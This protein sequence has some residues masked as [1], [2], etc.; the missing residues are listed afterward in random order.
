MSLDLPRLLEAEQLE[1]LLGDPRLLLVDCSQPQTYAQLHVPGAVHVPPAELVCGQPPAPGMLPSLERLEALFS[2]I[3]YRPEQHIVAYD[4]EGGGW[5]GR[6]LWTLEVIGHQAW[7]Y[8]NGGL[9]AWFKEGH[10][11]ENTPVQREPA[12]VSLSLRPGVIAELED[13]RASLERADVKIWD[14]RSAEE[15]AGLKQTARRNG[16]IPGAVNL[17]W[18]DT[19]DRERNLR[20]L[21]LDSLRDKLSALG[22]APGDAII[23]HC[24]SHHRSG[25]TWL[26]AHLLGHPARAYHG[27]WAEWG[28]RS[29]TPIEGP[30]A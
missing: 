13:V 27:S 1:A 15:Y 23:T 20:L 5:A 21:P 28:N 19:M 18:L 8:L 2:R 30:A 12:Q 4:D 17:D 3:G 26:I 24:Q 9:H 14:A 11:V 22:I 7:S 25:L 6:F 10:R 16:H 29:D